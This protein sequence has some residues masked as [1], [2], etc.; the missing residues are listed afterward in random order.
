M[1]DFNI[2]DNFSDQLILNNDLACI[3]QQIDLL[4]NTDINDVL[5]DSSYG[6]NYDTYLYT[7]GMSNIVLEDKIRKDI[8]KLNLGDY[9]VSVNVKIVEGSVRDIAF[10][11]ITLYDSYNEYSKTY[12]IK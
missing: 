7:V 5:G 4:F 3:I 11:D 8:E 9:K 12:M 1:I 6:S 2:L 10:I